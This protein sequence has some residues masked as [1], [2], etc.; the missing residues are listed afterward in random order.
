M[1][2]EQ[3][4]LKGLVTWYRSQVTALIK[5]FVS[6][7]YDL[8]EKNKTP[9]LFTLDGI[10]NADNALLLEMRQSFYFTNKAETPIIRRA[11]SKLGAQN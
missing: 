9:C 7:V 3:I 11:F 5:D 1:D 4:E 8:A 2:K 10:I 6:D